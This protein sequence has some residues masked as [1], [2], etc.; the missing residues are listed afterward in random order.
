V[1]GAGATA[2]DASR[3]AVR[4]SLAR[5][6]FRR[7]LPLETRPW[8]IL[9]VTTS[10]GRQRQL[11]PGFGNTGSGQHIPG[12]LTWP[13][14]PRYSPKHYRRPRRS[15]TRTHHIE[16]AFQGGSY[17]SP[18]QVVYC[19]SAGQK[20]SRSDAD[21]ISACPVAEG[22]QLRSVDRIA[23]LGEEKRS[24]R[25]LPTRRR[26]LGR[27]LTSHRWPHD[28][29]SEAVEKGFPRPIYKGRGLT[30]TTDYFWSVRASDRSGATAA[31]LP[32][33]PGA[34]AAAAAQS[35]ARRQHARASGSSN[36]SVGVPRDSWESLDA[37]RVVL[38]AELWHCPVR[39]VCYPAGAV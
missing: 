30:H 16:R 32:R 34:R 3:P 27:V 19:Y 36:P 23:P 26:A 24:T 20:R 39:N 38:R 21:R 25:F 22:L 2:S 15:S 14:R 31:R 1:V 35:L 33:E 10:R 18:D 5:L 28:R 17:S 7:Q 4:R 6:R 29:E 12:A 37:R 8:H 11:Q 13:A 9:A